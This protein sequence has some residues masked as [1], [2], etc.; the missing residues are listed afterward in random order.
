MF[1]MRLVKYFFD[2]D[3]VKLAISD[4]KRKALS[5]IGAFV[6]RRARHR[7]RP[8][9]KSGKVSAPGES[10]R[11]HTKVEPNLRAIWFAYDPAA[12]SVVIGPVKLNLRSFRNG[13][14]VHGTVPEVLEKGGKVGIPEVRRSDGTWVRADLR[15]RRRLAGRPVRVRQA[16]Y[17][18]R[19]FMGP[20]LDDEIDKGNVHSQFVIQR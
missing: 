5:R 14:K 1:E 15:S 11:Y 19:P 10:P 9:G 2:A 18:A 6:A 8:A 16:T 20:A 13:V 17:E 4:T 7:I 12:Q 3:V